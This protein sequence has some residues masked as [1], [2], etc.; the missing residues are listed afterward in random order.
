VI[1][2]Q[3]YFKAANVPDQILPA[4]TTELGTQV[5]IEWLA[6]DS[7]SLPIEAYLIEILSNDGVYRQSEQ[8]DGADPIILSNLFCII[9]LATISA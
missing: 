3:N 2:E 9:D 1:S 7:G 8:C 4:T 5:K 6:P